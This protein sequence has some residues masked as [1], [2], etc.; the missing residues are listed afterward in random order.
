MKIIRKTL[1]LTIWLSACLVTSYSYSNSNVPVGKSSARNTETSPVPISSHTF[2]FRSHPIAYETAVVR[3]PTKI[4]VPPQ[5]PTTPYRDVSPVLLLNGFGVGSFHQHRLIQALQQQSDQ[6]TVTDKNSN[7]DEPA[8]LATIIYTLDYLG[9]GRSWPVDSN[10]GQSE[11]EL[12]LRYCGQTWVD[13]IVAFLETIVLP[14]RES[15]FSSTRHYTAPP[16][17]VHLVGNSVGGHLAVFVAALRPDLVA[18]VTL[19][20]ATPVWGLNLPGWTGHLPAPFLPKT[21][22][23]FLFDQIRNLNTIEQYLAAAYVHRE[24][25]DATL[26][27]QIRACTESQGGHAAFASILWSP[28]VTLPTKPNDA[29]SNTKNDYK[30]INAFDEALSRLE[31]DVLLCF[32]ADDPWC[33]PAFAARMLRALGQRPTGKVQRYVEL[34]SVGHCP[35]HEAP[36]AV[37]YV[38]L[39]WLLSSNAQRQQIAL[40][41]APLSE[42]KRTS[43]RETWGVTELTERQA[44]DISL[45]LVDRLAVL[46]V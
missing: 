43:V 35:N 46:F 21:I 26:M 23:R 29:P 25:F 4:A 5:S 40:V 15:C 6:S 30:K 20:N 36:N 19:L 17:R 3:F 28:P 1:Q 13:Q 34:S 42:D 32:G 41:P 9:Q 45:S 44:D 12:G 39:P 31:C 18:S 14:A 37:A 38:L 11:A 7:R 33:K 10:D 2:L 22:G 27:Q 16:E 24:A 8:S